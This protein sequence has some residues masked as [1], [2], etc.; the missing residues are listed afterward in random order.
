MQTIQL[1]IYSTFNVLTLSQV[2]KKEMGQPNFYQGRI[3]SELPGI[4]PAMIFP[5]FLYAVAN[6]TQHL[7]IGAHLGLVIENPRLL[8][9]I[10]LFCN[11]KIRGDLF[12]VKTL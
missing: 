6:N 1:R 4:Q 11:W 9:E 12:V 5:S 10:P 2:L 7:A 8:S 3:L